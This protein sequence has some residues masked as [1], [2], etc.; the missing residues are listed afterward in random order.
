MDLRAKA[1][2]LELTPNTRFEQIFHKDHRDCSCPMPM[3]SKK[4]NDAL[5]RFQVIRLCC[6]ASTVQKIAEATGIDCRDL[7]EV[8][9]FD[10]R[11]VWDCTELHQADS[12]DGTYMMR[13]RGAPPK[14]LLKRFEEK[15]IEVKNL[16]EEE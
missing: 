7:L 13:E 3:V 8:F 5:G 2:Q 16:P 12:G 6:M 15:G 14:W 4:W 9:E 10:P 1:K 11:W